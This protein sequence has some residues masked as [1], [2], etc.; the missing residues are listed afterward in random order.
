MDSTFITYG[1]RNVSV[2]VEDIFDQTK[3]V[4]AGTRDMLISAVSDMTRRSRAIRI[5]AFGCDSTNAIS[6][7][8]SAQRQQPYDTVPRYDIK[9]S[10]SQFDENLIRNQQDAGVGFKPFLNFGMSVDAATS[11]LGLDL[12]VLTTD[13]L[14]ILPGV[15]SRNS[16]AIL[17]QGKGADADA[18]YHKFGVTYSMS[19]SKSEGSAQALRG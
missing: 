10:V 4:N 14:S 3:K 19:L 17:K 9:G 15:T 13:D 18:A 6:F 16:V 11:I 2:L 12:S 8:A 7:L 5:N 1:V